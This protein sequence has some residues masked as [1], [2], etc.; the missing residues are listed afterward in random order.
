MQH[1]Q[2]CRGIKSEIEGTNNDVL[3]QQYVTHLYT[4]V[5][6]TVCDVTPLSGACMLHQG[7]CVCC[8]VCCIQL[9]QP[10]TIHLHMVNTCKSHA[11]CPGR[12]H[13]VLKFASSCSRYILW[14]DGHNRVCSCTRCFV[15][16][17]T[18]GLKKYCLPLTPVAMPVSLSL[19]G[20]ASSS[21]ATSSLMPDIFLIIA[22]S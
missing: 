10:H 11:V 13:A 21:K 3:K 6:R 4:T 16:M 14:E 15:V 7:D 17:T 8:H 20:T 18:E 9:G 1:R 2:V 22:D 5:R 19:I 12:L